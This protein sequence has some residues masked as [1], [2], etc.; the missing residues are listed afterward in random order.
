MSIPICTP[1]TELYELWLLPMSFIRQNSAIYIGNTPERKI[2]YARCRAYPNILKGYSVYIICVNRSFLTTTSKPASYSKDSASRPIDRYH[3]WSLV[4]K[5]R[6]NFS[7]VDSF[8][9]GQRVL[10][11]PCVQ[12]SIGPTD[13]VSRFSITI[14]PVEVAQISY[15]CCNPSLKHYGCGSS[16]NIK[17]RPIKSA[18]ESGHFVLQEPIG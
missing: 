11:D 15:Y 10:Y 9:E 17:R 18:S 3:V 5:A 6:V 7:F 1:S 2:R 16:M 12:I 13:Q 8:K 14:I 4:S